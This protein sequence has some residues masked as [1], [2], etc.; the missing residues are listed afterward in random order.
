MSVITS[1]YVSSDNNIAEMLKA[2]G[3]LSKVKDDVHSLDLAK[4]APDFWKDDL[5][6]ISRT[7]IKQRLGAPDHAYCLNEYMKTQ[8]NIHELADLGPDR[9]FNGFCADP[10]HLGYYVYDPKD[11]H[12]DSRLVEFSKADV[13]KIEQGARDLMSL[14]KPDKDGWYKRGYTDYERVN[15]SKYQVV[16]KDDGKTICWHRNY[17]HGIDDNVSAYISKALPDE[18]LQVHVSTEGDLQFDGVMKDCEVIKQNFPEETDDFEK[19]SDVG[20][21]I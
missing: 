18:A 12:S 19:S 6:T 3:A 2:K 21:S 10:D 8:M 15:L 17:A 14:W 5:A 13:D 1:Y 7:G 9:R 11:D 20:F 16:V 4:A